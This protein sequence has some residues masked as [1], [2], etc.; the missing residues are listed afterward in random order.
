MLCCGIGYW[1]LVVGGWRS[2]L[3]PRGPRFRTL[4]SGSAVSASRRSAIAVWRRRAGP[5]NNEQPAANNQLL[6]FLQ[7]PDD[8]L[9]RFD[10]FVAL[11]FAFRKAYMQLELLRGWTECEG[12]RLG[13]AWLRLRRGL[14]RLLAGRGPF[15][16]QLLDERDHF[17]GLAL[18]NYL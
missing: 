4:D 15:A 11:D 7:F 8:F 5:T 1:Y 17:L 14:A 10:D 13:T 9:E 3:G 18:P 6:L 2:L 12:E 16:R